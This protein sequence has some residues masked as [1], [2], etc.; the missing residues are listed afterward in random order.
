[1]AATDRIIELDD[2]VKMKSGDV[3]IPG[4]FC[5]PAGGGPF[6]ALILFHGTDG[7]QPTHR[8]LAVDLAHE[9][10]A[11]LVPEWFGP[12]RPRRLSWEMVPPA[13]LKAM[14][15]WI[16]KQPEVDD[17]RLGL[18][19]ASRGGG[20]ALYAAS[21][22]P[23]IRAVVNFFGLTCWSGGMEEF[24]RL[25]FNPGDHLDFLRRVSSPILSFHG[26]RDTVVK[27]ENTFMLDRTCRRFGLEHHRVI[28]PG[29]DHSF[30][31]PGNPRYH[32]DAHRDSWKKNLAFLNRR[33]SFADRAEK[34]PARP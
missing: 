14:G 23:G 21:L 6:P 19:G 3:V 4:F 8:K 27:V 22:I 12:E 29:V 11:V 1:M 20:L 2:N 31:W 28:Y 18:M 17:R 5:R 13:D 15:E 9:G 26:D 24:R 33:L 16:K 30:I 32:R 34:R 10:Y 25:P 7:F